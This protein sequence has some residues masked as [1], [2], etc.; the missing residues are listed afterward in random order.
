MNNFDEAVKVVLK[1]E[2]GFVN[3]V[4]DP[5]GATNF[6]I[7]LRF[8]KL[9]GILLDMDADGDMDVDDIKAMT[10]EK[11][12]AFY[13][14]RF[15]NRYGY[16]RI[17]DLALATK[18]L[19]TC[20]NAGSHQTHF[21]LQRALRACGWPIDADGIY[22]PKT[23]QAIT[24]TPSFPILTAFRSE[25]ASFYRLLLVGNA[26]FREFENGWLYRAYS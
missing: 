10:V 8:L 13:R 16:G 22:G 19:D 11:A 15:W 24:A 14:E 21:I 2:G 3:N 12:I 18:V 17:P 23:Q 9:E 20:V 4:N 1:H 7:S 5:G 25:Q 26:K 6:G